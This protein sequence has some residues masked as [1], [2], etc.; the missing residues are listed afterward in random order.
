MIEHRERDRQMKDRRM[1][2]ETSLELV[3]MIVEAKIS[4]EE[5]MS[6]SMI[7]SSS[8]CLSLSAS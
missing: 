2:E 4:T 7:L 8:L 5:L 3:H 6:M 1:V